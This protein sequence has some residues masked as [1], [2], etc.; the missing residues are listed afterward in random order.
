MAISMGCLLQEHKE[1]VPKSGLG[2]QEIT[3]KMNMHLLTIL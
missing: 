3:M 2:S 1:E